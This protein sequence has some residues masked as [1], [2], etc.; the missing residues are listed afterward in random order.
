MIFIIQPRLGLSIVWLFNKHVLLAVATI[1]TT[2]HQTTPHQKGIRDRW[3]ELL[4]TCCCSA[5]FGFFYYGTILFPHSFVCLHL[6]RL[7]PVQLSSTHRTALIEFRLI[8]YQEDDLLIDPL[9]LNVLEK[10]LMY[11][12]WFCFTFISI[13]LNFWIEIHPFKWKWKFQQIHC[14]ICWFQHSRVGMMSP[15]NYRIN[16]T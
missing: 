12:W 7:R 4:A 14:C 3:L 10:W 9:S 15:I 13:V 11:K 2:P 6:R 16:F 8:R 1:I 5:S